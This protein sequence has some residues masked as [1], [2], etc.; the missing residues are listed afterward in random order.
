MAAPSCFKSAVYSDLKN[1]IFKERILWK[2]FIQSVSTDLP[3]EEVPLTSCNTFLPSSRKNLSQARI[4][5]YIG[6]S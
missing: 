3:A 4:E 6:L 1:Q 2:S 5:K